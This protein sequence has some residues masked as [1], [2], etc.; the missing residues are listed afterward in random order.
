MELRQN[1]CTA[2]EPTQTQGIDM[3]A[4]EAIHLCNIDWLLYTLY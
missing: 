2:Y 1:T 4:N 3:K